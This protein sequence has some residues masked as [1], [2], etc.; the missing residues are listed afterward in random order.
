[1]DCVA[2]YV[3]YRV[4]EK[5]DADDILQETWLAAFR[6]FDRIRGAESFKAWVLGIARHK[7]M[8]YYR[9]RQEHT[10]LDEIPE[11]QLADGRPGMTDISPVEEALAAM[12]PDKKQ[13]LSLYYWDELPVSEI[14]RRLSIPEGTVKSRLYASRQSFKENYPRKPKGEQDMRKKLPLMLPEYTITPVDAE[15]FA[16]RWE[17]LMGW[18][19][20]PRLGEKIS[21]AMYD[22]PS[23]R[24]GYGYELQV[25]GRAQVH[26]IDGVEII[27]REKRLNEDHA[28]GGSDSEIIDRT[29][30]AQLTDTH[31]RYLATSF[32]QNG[33]KKYVTFLDGDAFLP[34]WGFGEDN[35]GNEV[36][37]R[38]K[39][40]ILRRGNELTTRD[41]PFLL[42]IVGRYTVS[43]LGKTFD[44]V[45]VMDVE[46]YDEGVATEQY[47]DRSGRTV[48]WR[49][50]NRNDWAVDRYGKPWTELMP[51]NEVISINGKPYVEW[52]DC[53]SDYI[54]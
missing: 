19:L 51:D 22:L 21:W 10:S 39:G 26:G 30:V 23:R 7:L 47:L 27:A 2:R 17:E 14:A 41:K 16:I 43:I 28:F 32:M 48:L 42:D 52:Y 40:D 5:A 11:A 8:D 31:C 12:P 45:C 34:N 44:T 49:R 36:N 37:L 50:F 13:L 54:L 18:L 20:V 15:P 1:M 38:A 3:R 6:S 53:I 35:C 9:R 4:S 33:V 24:G 46:T 29:F 25:T